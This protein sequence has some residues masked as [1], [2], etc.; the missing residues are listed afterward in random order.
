MRV[1]SRLRDRQ[2]GAAII[3]AMLVVTLAAVVVSGLFWREHVAVRSVENRLALAQARWIER[4]ALDWAKVILRADARATGT[5]DHLGE[6]WAVPVLDTRM[7]ETVTAGAKLDEGSNRTAM[8]AGQIYDA[9]SRFNVSSLVDGR[10]APSAPNVKAFRKLLSLLGKPESAADPIVA[11]VVQGA[12]A[13][14]PDGKV[15]QAS[16][17]PLTRLAD[18]LDVPN[19]DPSV[20]AAL[21][22]HAIVLPSNA[23]RININTAGA[24]VLAA[25]I[26]GLDVSGARR[27]VSNRERVPAIDLAIAASGFG[28]NVTLD[29]ALLSVGSSF[30]LVTGVIRYDRV[31]SQTETLLQRKNNDVEVIWQLRL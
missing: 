20:V 21:E 14:A 30:F 15:T 8:L 24:E 25:A 11:R 19:L 26:D 4:A 31:E 17:P 18:L 3:T 22:A 2:R 16:R 6:A 23:T 12:D 1:M 29:P 10:G 5:V 27:Y 9:Q 28:G 13:I 7:D